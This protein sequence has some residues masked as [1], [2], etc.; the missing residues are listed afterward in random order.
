MKRLTILFTVLLFITILSSIK[1]H[2]NGLRNMIGVSYSYVKPSGDLN[3]DY[4]S[5][6]SFSVKYGFGYM[7]PSFDLVYSRINLNGKG[8]TEDT[9]IDCL[10]LNFC[11]PNLFSSS[12][13]FPI[14]PSLGIGYYMPENAH[15]GL[16]I[17]AGA[18]FRFP[19]AYNF[20]ELFGFYHYVFNGSNNTEFFEIRLGYTISWK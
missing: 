4:N 7:S 8:V 18:G 6:D 5:S 20:L 10:N 19:R 17:N 15:N 13:S 9:N 1:A 2:A 16:G 12:D 14:I 11:A 3:D